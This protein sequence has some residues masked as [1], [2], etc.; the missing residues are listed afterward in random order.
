MK[1]CG[2]IYSDM[3]FRFSLPIFQLCTVQT[4]NTH[5]GAVCD[6]CHDCAVIVIGSPRM[7]ENSR[8]KKIKTYLWGH[9][10]L[11]TPCGVPTGR[12]LSPATCRRPGTWRSVAGP[13]GHLF[14]SDVGRP[15][16]LRG[17]TRGSS[18]RP[19]K[20]LD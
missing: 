10:C 9:I 20:T 15:Q 4:P 19:A 16:H 18:A 1:C 12:E 17:R 13:P 3:V 2:K 6:S 14:P 8:L 7:T 5:R 11:Q